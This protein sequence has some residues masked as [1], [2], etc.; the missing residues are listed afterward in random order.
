MEVQMVKTY[1]IAIH[2]VY[3]LLPNLEAANNAFNL[4]KSIGDGLPIGPILIGAA[5]S[6][7]IL[8][9]SVSARG[10][11]NMTALAVVDAQDHA[12]IAG[13]ADTTDKAAE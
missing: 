7:H 9:P 13:G 11:V 2:Q 3:H 8:T 1:Q 10:I 6:A 12:E 5:R 4:L